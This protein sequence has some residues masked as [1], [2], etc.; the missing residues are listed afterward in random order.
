MTNPLYLHVNYFCL[1]LLGSWHAIEHYPVQNNYPIISVFMRP[2]LPSFTLLG[3]WDNDH[4]LYLKTSTEW[5][6]IDQ[7]IITLEGNKHLHTQKI[8]TI[9]YIFTSN[10]VK[11]NT[12]STKKIE[13]QNKTKYKKEKTHLPTQGYFFIFKISC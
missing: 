7:T 2:S 5:K 6:C 11:R 10:Q 8:M 1:C 3:V 13:N 9:C 12:K 4:L